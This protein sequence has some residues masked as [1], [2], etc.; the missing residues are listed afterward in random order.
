MMGDAS[1]IQHNSCGVLAFL[2]TSDYY[3]FN[4]PVFGCKK[5]TT[6]N[7]PLSKCLT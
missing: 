3:H 5:Y 6:Q 7:E 1:K 2:L 4:L